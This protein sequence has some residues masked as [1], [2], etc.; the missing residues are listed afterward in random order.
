MLQN[1]IHIAAVAVLAVYH[2]IALTGL[3]D[4]ESGL[5]LLTHLTH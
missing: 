4:N 2:T 5:H 1:S 3:K